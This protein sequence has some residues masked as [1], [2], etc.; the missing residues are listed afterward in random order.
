MKKL[1]Y[2]TMSILNISICSGMLPSYYSGNE[3]T[4][5]KIVLSEISDEEALEKASE[6]YDTAI[7]LQK[8][9]QISTALSKYEAA[10]FGGETSIPSPEELYGN[11]RVCLFKNEFVDECFISLLKKS[12]ISYASSSIASIFM[13]E[14]K[15]LEAAFWYGMSYVNGNS[16][17]RNSFETAVT[18]YNS[19]VKVKG[20]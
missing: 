15:Y 18:Y 9:G 3:E 14:E 16:S 12:F 17:A 20:E 1:I 19:S 4:K 11:F 7:E 2:I 5:K 8:S 6:T 10:F 13:Q